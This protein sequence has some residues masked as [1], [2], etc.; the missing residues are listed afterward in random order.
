MKKKTKT[1]LKVAGA[2][3]GTLAAIG[4]ATNAYEKR[5]TNRKNNATIR[6]SQAGYDRVMYANVRQV[7]KPGKKQ[8]IRP[9][10]QDE[11]YYDAISWEGSTPSDGSWLE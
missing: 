7:M 9:P 3:L 6:E 1:A 5:E 4:V 8:H 11:V 10:D 2:A